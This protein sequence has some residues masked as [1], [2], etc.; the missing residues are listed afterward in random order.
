MLAF[1]NRPPRESTGHNFDVIRTPASGKL[2]GIIT[3]ENLIGCPTHYFQLHTVP[4]QQPECQPC[5]LGL[6]WRWHG[7]VTIFTANTHLH[8]LL[9]LTAPPAEVLATYYEQHGTLRGCEIIAGRVSPR[10]NGRVRL[11]TKPANLENISLPTPPDLRLILATIW[12][13]P[14]LAAQVNGTQKG[15]PRINVKTQD[16]HAPA[17]IPQRIGDFLE[18]GGHSL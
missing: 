2:R 15:H 8:Q 6:P 10:P 12:N 4:C 17:A 1:S 18:T 16:L 3:S 14:E 9:E 13:L 5:N 7:Y 11:I